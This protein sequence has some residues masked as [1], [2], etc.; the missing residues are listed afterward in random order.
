MTH[1][2]KTTEKSEKREIAS[3][4]MT[5]GL[6]VDFLTAAKEVRRQWILYNMLSKNHSGSDRNKKMERKVKRQMTSGGLSKEIQHICNRV[7]KRV[8]EKWKE[9][10]GSRE[11]S[12]IHKRH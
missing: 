5:T 2:N 12:R 6:V 7:S 9:A 10:I 3:K 11:F 1:P 4:G 8:E